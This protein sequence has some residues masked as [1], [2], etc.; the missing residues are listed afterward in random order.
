MASLRV[1]IVG[2]GFVSRHHLRAWRSL[3]NI[4]LV[5]VC[6]RDR[7]AAER[8]AAEFE[9]PA[10]HT[11]L[12]EM[13]D[14]A[15]PDV[16][17]IAT[18]PT[19]HLPFIREA[20][21]R[22]IPVLCQKPLAPTLDEA[23]EIVRVAEVAN[24][25]IMV[26]EN[27]RWRPWFREIERLLR[28]GAIGAPFYASLD[29]RHA[30]AVTTHDFPDRPSSLARQPFMATMPRMVIYESLIHPL[31]VC[32]FLFGEPRS[33]CAQTRHVSPLVVG[34]DLALIVLNFDHLTARV[35]Q[36]LA[37]RGYPT[38]VLS[39]VAAIEGER[40]TIFLDRD[41]RVRVVVDTPAEQRKF[42]AFAPAGDAYQAGYTA[43]IAHFVECLRSGAPF[44]TPPRENLKTLQLVFAA[45][46]SAERNQVV[47]IDR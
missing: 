16:L 20:A 44:E 4:A 12:V 40:G 42:E 33:V 25:R 30:G 8:R 46:E 19:T 38:P 31:D 39:E 29:R 28:A 32:R 41:G 36:S 27:W 3:Q 43:C 11:D 35:E 6:D 17:D 15:R 24:L 21:A 37:S 22:G 13:L 18:P 9:V 7:A 2:C 26:H 1:A 5:A 45:Y 34:E 23:R 14:A 10:V 47:L